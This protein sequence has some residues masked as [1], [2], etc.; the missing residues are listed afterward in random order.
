MFFPSSPALHRRCTAQKTSFHVA[1]PPFCRMTCRSEFLITTPWKEFTCLRPIPTTSGALPCTPRS[2]SSSQAVVRVLW[3]LFMFSSS[4]APVCCGV[5][6]CRSSWEGSGVLEQEAN[7]TVV[8]LLFLG[9]CVH[10]FLMENHLYLK[11]K[12]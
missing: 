5:R 7:V 9:R 12:I 11:F 3:H 8:I 10:V 1:F 4:Q 2:P 6:A